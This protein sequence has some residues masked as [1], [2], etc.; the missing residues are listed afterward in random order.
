MPFRCGFRRIPNR[1]D[2]DRD[3]DDDDD[4]DDSDNADDV[5]ITGG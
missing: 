2:D 3:G 1:F 4:D 5:G